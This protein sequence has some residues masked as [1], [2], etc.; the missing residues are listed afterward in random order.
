MAICKN[1][2]IGLN[3]TAKVI[4]VLL[5]I[6]QSA[7]LDFIILKLD[8]LAPKPSRYVWPVIDAI[9]ALFWILA[10]AGSFWYFTKPPELEVRGRKKMVKVV[11]RELSFPHVYWLVYSA[12]LVAKIQ[13]VF[14]FRDDLFKVDPSCPIC[15]VT[16]F[17]IVLSLAGIMFP[18]LAYSRDEVGHT[19]KYKYLLRQLGTSASLDILDSVMVLDILFTVYD[20]QPL[21]SAMEKAINTFSSLCLLLP[22][23]PLLALRIA[24]TIVESGQSKILDLA[25][26]I[27]STLYL[28]TVNVPLLCIRLV[29]WAR[30]DIDVS[31][32]LIK[33]LIGIIKGVMDIHQ[34]VKIIRAWNSNQNACDATPRDTPTN[35]PTDMTMNM[36]AGGDKTLLIN[37]DA[38]YQ[39]I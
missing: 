8:H 5:L 32:F 35:M 21:D 14:E 27:N 9:V 11:M 30:R 15:T 19:E 25:L 1:F 39:F 28:I 29:L 13:R 38:D 3:A 22:V 10:M 26:V 34:E 31:T 18:L 7:I 4:S 24:S 33:N 36:P 37:N 12:V 20:D 2:K 17:K 6:I 16:T 23:V